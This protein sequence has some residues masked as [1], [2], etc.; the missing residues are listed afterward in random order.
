MIWAEKKQ[1]YTNRPVIFPLFFDDS[2]LF[3]SPALNIP[4][5][6]FSYNFNGKFHISSLGE[7]SLYEIKHSESSS[8]THNNSQFCIKALSTHEWNVLHMYKFQLILLFQ[9][10]PKQNLDS[11][12]SLS[13]LTVFR[14]TFVTA[15]LHLLLFCTATFMPTTLVLITEYLP[16]SQGSAA[17][18]Y[19][20][21]FFYAQ[22]V[23]SLQQWKNLDLSLLMI[24]DGNLASHL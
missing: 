4:C 18:F 11:L 16:S 8:P 24:L 7:V 13:W 3:L 21:R 9:V 6:P 23:P 20:V 12:A 15:M 19:S 22:T 10:R 2:K 14:L 1:Y 17:H 5:L